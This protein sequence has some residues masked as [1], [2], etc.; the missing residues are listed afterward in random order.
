MNSSCKGIAVMFIINRPENPSPR[1]EVHTQGHMAPTSAHSN[2]AIS[3]SE[4]ADTRFNFHCNLDRA[5]L[6]VLPRNI[7]S[8]T[9]SDLFT[10]MGQSLCGLQCGDLFLI[11]KSSG[12]VS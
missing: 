6:V 5:H 9:H 8:Q 11:S 12:P 4:P 1:A 3:K 7:L 10:P 2:P